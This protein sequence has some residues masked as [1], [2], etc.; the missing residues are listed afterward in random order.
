MKTRCEASRVVCVLE[1]MFSCDVHPLLSASPATNTFL[2]QSK[3][4]LTTWARNYQLVLRRRSNLPRDGHG[5]NPCKPLAEYHGRFSERRLCFV[6]A[7]WVEKDAPPHSYHCISICEAGV[8]TLSRVLH[9]SHGT[10]KGTWMYG[11]PSEYSFTLRKRL[12]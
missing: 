10:S 8:S 12:R 11:V 7:K 4:L 5:T 2:I 3:E 1:I 6:C 9:A